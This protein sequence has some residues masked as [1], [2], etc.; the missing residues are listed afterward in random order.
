[1]SRALC[2]GRYE[3]LRRLG[4]GGMAEVH[5]ARDEVLGRNVALKVLRERLVDEEVFLKRF[6]A[7]AGRTPVD[8]M[9]RCGPRRSR[10]S[11][12]HP[13]AWKGCSANFALRGFHEVAERPDPTPG[14]CLTHRTEAMAA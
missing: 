12:M 5:L 11:L 6:R 13:S 7:R 8:P 10:S 1:V 9:E 4:G 14:A 3:I 2:D